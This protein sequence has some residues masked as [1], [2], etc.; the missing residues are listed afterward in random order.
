ML[1][2]FFALSFLFILIICC[3]SACKNAEENT[4]VGE[5]SLNGVN[6]S[7]EADGDFVWGSKCGTYEIQEVFTDSQL[8]LHFDNAG[9]FDIVPIYL[10]EVV[11]EGHI[12]LKDE[13]GH[14]STMW[15]ID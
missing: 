5:W 1:K 10:I 13:D 15:R 8:F 12:V 11:D 14:K 4:I 6:V 3:F 9:A 2:K 7:F